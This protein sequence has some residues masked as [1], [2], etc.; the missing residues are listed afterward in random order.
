M[1]IFKILFWG[2]SPLSGGRQRQVSP[3][4]LTSTPIHSVRRKFLLRGTDYGVT[5]KLDAALNSLKIKEKTFLVALNPATRENFELFMTNWYRR[6]ARKSFQDSIDRW[7]PVFQATGHTIAAPRLKIFSM[8][9]A[10]GRCYY[11]KGL[12]TMNLHLVKTPQECIDYI[13]LHELCHFIVNNHS[14]DFYALVASFMPHWK[15]TEQQLKT[16]AQKHR[17]I[18]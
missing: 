4:R 13:V 12:I 7:M 16:F 9:R 5:L 6:Q 10:W 17:V 18:Q 3:K 11:T 14:K 8:R 1:G 2:R 15:D